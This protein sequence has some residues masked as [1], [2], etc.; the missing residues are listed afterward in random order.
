[1]AEQRERQRFSFTGIIVIAVLGGVTY[2]LVQ[3]RNLLTLYSL[4]TI[5]L[6]GLLIAVAFDLGIG[7]AA[8]PVVVEEPETPEAPVIDQTAKVKRRKRRR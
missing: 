7:K 1:M 2:F 8:E 4:A 5:L 3:S 6:V